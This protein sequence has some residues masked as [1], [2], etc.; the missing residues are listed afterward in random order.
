MRGFLINPVIAVIAQLD[1]LATDQDP[2]ASGALTSGYDD[3][4]KE[5]RL[6]RRKPRDFGAP[7]PPSTRRE[8][9]PIEI[10]TQIEARNEELQQEM[11]AGS[12][13]GAL[14]TLVFHFKDLEAIGMVDPTNGKALLKVNDR[15]CSLKHKISGDLIQ[16]YP[17]PPGLYAQEIL[18]V[19]YGLIGGYRNL[20]LVRFED[21]EQSARGGR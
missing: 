16:E 12:T 7:R 10:P 5:P 3:V 14:L 18:P 9:Q 1:T 4:L 21:R 8:K 20:L 6:V 15:L 19:S 17:T 11:A 2:D 13:Q